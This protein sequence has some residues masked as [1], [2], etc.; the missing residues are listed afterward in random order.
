M[1]Y[2]ILNSAGEPV[3]LSNQERFVASTLQKKFDNEIKPTLPGFNEKR[4]AL[5]YEIDMTSLSQ[6][7]KS[8]TEQKFYEV[9]FADYLPVVVGEG[10]WSSNLI[11]YRSFDVADDFE[12]GILNTGNSHAKLASVSTAIDAVTVPVI[13]W[14]K[15]ITY[16]IM[17]L[18]QASRS[19]NWDLVTSME[20]ARHRN[21]SLGLQQIAFWGSKNNSAVKG[22]LTLTGVNSNTTLITKKISAMTALEFQAL[23]AGLLEAYRSNSSRTAQPT[24]FIIPEDDY[25]GLASSVDETYPL[26]SR[27]E[28]LLESMRTLTRN[29]SFE[30]LPS[31]YA[32]KSL[33]AGIT[34]LNK[35]RYVLYNG[36]DSNALRMDIPVDYTNT[37]QNTLNGFTFQNVGYGQYSGAMAYR[38]AEILYFD[39]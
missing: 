7:I 14:G 23:L 35:N 29:P 4:N 39:W 18:M 34:G 25:N 11:K 12:S 17:D 37:M 2:Q 15:E 5:A 20:G 22:L 9:N 28:R 8:V 13:N 10:A 26:K 27:L 21:W 1:K 6:I 24:K 30:I 31:A 19:G 36:S 33:N 38:P 16:S 3:K 32:M